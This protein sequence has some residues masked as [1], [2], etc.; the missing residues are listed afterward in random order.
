MQMNGR[1]TATGK[2]E[3]LPDADEEGNDGTTNSGY[4]S[5]AARRS[6]R[7][8]VDGETGRR[9]AVGGREIEPDRNRDT[10]RE[11]D[12]DK[13]VSGTQQLIPMGAGAVVTFSKGGTEPPETGEGMP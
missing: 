12:T 5:S 1:R 11:R 9:A 10:L 7:K 13:I 4:F 2:S 6:S 3:H 8:A